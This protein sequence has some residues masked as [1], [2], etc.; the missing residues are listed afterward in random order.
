[1]GDFKLDIEVKVTVKPVNP[2]VGTTQRGPWEKNLYVVKEE[3]S[4]LYHNVAKADVA[5]L[6]ANA[7]P[8]IAEQQ[9]IGLKPP[10]VVGTLPNGAIATTTAVLNATGDNQGVSTAPTCQYG[11]TEA[12]GSEQAAAT[13]PDASADG[14]N[15]DYIF[16]LTGLSASTKYYWRVKLVSTSGTQYGPLKSFTTPAT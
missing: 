5:T 12:L 16:N 9:A 1:M 11:A 13:T 7:M 2:K 14:T 10:K 15:T 8:V 3:K 4:V 6:V